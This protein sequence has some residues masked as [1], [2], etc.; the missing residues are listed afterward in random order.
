MAIEDRA[1]LID[2]T[3]EI[4]YLNGQSVTFDRFFQEAGNPGQDG[5]S[6]FELWA[7]EP[8]NAGKS[9]DDFYEYLKGKD[10]VSPLQVLI[11]SSNGN[12][13]KSDDQIKSTILS[14]LLVDGSNGVLLDEECDKYKYCWKQDGIEIIVNDAGE[15]IGLYN[16]GSLSF[17]TYRTLLLPGKVGKR[18]IVGSEDVNSKAVF[19]CEVYE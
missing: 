11:Q 10:G 7:Q 2:R 4:I 5:L 6:A 8:E 17:G 9:L 3:N 15:R 18:I 1:F 16:G 14:V 13:F 19:T 12:F